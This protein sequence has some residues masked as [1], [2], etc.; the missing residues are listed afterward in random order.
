MCSDAVLAVVLQTAAPGPHSVG[1]PAPGSPVTP[2][3]E[4]APT[5]A[6][7]A[8]TRTVRQRQSEDVP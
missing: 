7:A 4:H 5:T 6:A 3:T 8:A 1:A 2:A